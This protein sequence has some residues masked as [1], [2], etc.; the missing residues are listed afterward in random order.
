MQNAILNERRLTEAQAGWAAPNPP[1]P[2]GQIWA[3]PSTA[4]GAATAPITDGP[5]STWR[6]AMTVRGTFTTTSLLF[7]LLLVAAYAG[8]Q[9]TP[10]PRSTPPPTRSGTASPASPSSAS[11]SASPP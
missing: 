9:A 11:P 5:V 3:P 2:G 8:W 7:V 1:S 4:P 6:G 10:E